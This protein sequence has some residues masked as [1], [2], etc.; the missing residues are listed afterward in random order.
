MP[1]LADTVTGARVV[2]S[3]MLQASRKHDPEGR[4]PLMDHIRELRNRLVKAAIALVLAMVIG[5]VFF[6][7]I[8]NFVSHPFCSADIRG[9]SGC[10]V[11]GDQLV[12]TGV[13]DPFMLRVKI[14]FFVGLIVSSPV[15]LYQIWAFIAPGLYRREK[16]WAYLF[17]GAAAPLFAAGAVLAYLV[18]SRGLRY[19]LGLTPNG[20]INLPSIDTYLGYFQ[21]MIL[22]FGLAF[23]LPLAVIVLNMAGILTH[24]RFAKWRKLMIFGAFLFA[25]IANPSPDPISMLLLAVPCVVLVEVAEVIIWFND[26]RRARIPDPYDDLADNE[27]SPLEMGD[28]AEMS[29][30]GTGPDHSSLN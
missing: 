15:W 3:R 2:G 20:V 29:D 8:W 26:R 1:K 12:V 27:V 14:A 24:E 22:G 30:T 18:M 10:R 21:G 9:H 23:E 25:G 7:P 17:V 13:F 19:L 4:M 6:H 28:T 16:R 11:A 5:F